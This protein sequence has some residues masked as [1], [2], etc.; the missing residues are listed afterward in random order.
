MLNSILIVLL[1]ISGNIFSAYFWVWLYKEL[2]HTKITLKVLITQGFISA[3]SAL[4]ILRF[5]GIQT[6]ISKVIVEESTKTLTS[7]ISNKHVLA[8]DH[9]VTWVLAGIGFAVIENI[10]YIYYL[11]D[12]NLLQVSI[13]RILTNSILHALFTGCIGFWIYQFIKNKNILKKYSNGLIFISM[14]LISHILYNHFL[15]SSVAISLLFVI[16]WYFFLSYFLYKSDR[17]FLD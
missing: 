17:L 13:M 16:V 7:E 10:I 5:T 4:G 1:I 6:L 14:G 8:S 11:I 3:L 9:I 12:Q 2:F 15:Q